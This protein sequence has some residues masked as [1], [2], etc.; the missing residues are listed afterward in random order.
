MKLALKC[1]TR[2][3]NSKPNALR[4]AGQVPAVLYGHKGA[5][6]VNLTIEAKVAELLVRDAAINNTLID[7]SIPDLSWSGKALLRE[8]QTHPWKGAKLYHLSF[9]AVGTHDSLDV[10]LPVHPI[11]E[12]KGIRL[13]GGSLD[14]QMNEMR[15]RCAPDNIPNAVEV[16]VSDLGVGESLHVREVKL[17]AGVEALDDPD[18]V[19]VMVSQS[20]GGEAATEAES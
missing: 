5:E 16:D 1:Q 17:P 18:Q 19:V 10:V 8:V 6:S 14:L 4:R 3:E 15:I 13:G 9:F 12:A 20:R 11:G 7:L 2:P